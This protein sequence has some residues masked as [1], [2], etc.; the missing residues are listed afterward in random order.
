[1]PLGQALDS[2]AAIAILANPSI[3]DA[4]DYMAK[5]RRGA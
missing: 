1:M 3:S 2:T 5:L 4:L